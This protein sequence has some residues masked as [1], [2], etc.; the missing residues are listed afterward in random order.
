MLTVIKK[1]PPDVR[2]QVSSIMI[3]VYH[4]IGNYEYTIYD[5]KNQ[6]LC[7]KRRIGYM[8]YSHKNLLYGGLW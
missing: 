8:V 5:K 7:V 2:I 1:S 3:C 6:D 4:D